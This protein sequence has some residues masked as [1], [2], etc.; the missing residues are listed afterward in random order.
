MISFYPGP[1]QVAPETA[2][3]MTDALSSGILGMNHRSNDFMT[4]LRRTK[5]TLRKKLLIP[6]D[7]EIVMASSA[8]ECWEI[9]AQSLASGLSYHLYN[10]AFGEKWFEYTRRIHSQSLG[11]HYD[12]EKELSPRNLDLSE[13]SALICLTQ[14]ETSNG[15]RIS[16]EILKTFREAFPA[17]LIA[18]DATSSMAGEHL[19]FTSA[20]VWFASVQKCFGLPSGLAVMILSPRAVE[21]AYTINERRHYNSLAFV[22]D[23]FRKDQTPYTPNVLDIYLLYRTMK[24]RAVI[25]KVH[26]RLIK[27]MEQLAKS[28]SKNPL[29]NPLI[30]NDSV[31]SQTVMAIELEPKIIPGLKKAARHEGFLLG[32]GYGEWKGSSMRIANFP[33]VSQDDWKRL[34][35]FIKGYSPD[36]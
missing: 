24:R 17:P 1:S 36:S 29:I 13:L 10:G 23:N 8:T 20:D 16:G 14:N 19:D 34:R 11:L 31:W 9:I 5:K 22:L 21:A 27:R 25:T 4:L 15:T 12:P 30:D 7:Y 28:I 35:T 6:D 26:S 3:F 2:E 33:A 18:V 32:N